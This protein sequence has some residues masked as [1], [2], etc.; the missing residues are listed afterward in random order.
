MVGAPKFPV[1][2]T[3]TYAHDVRAIVAAT[4]KAGAYYIVNPNNPTGTITP[5]ADIVWLL[6]NKP[7]GSVVIVDEAYLD[8]SNEESCIDL[9]RRIRTSS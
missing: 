5:K 6:K 9:V 1:K 4:P 7:A 3:S 2:L 8:F